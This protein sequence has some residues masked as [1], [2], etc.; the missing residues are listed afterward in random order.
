MVITQSEFRELRLRQSVQDLVDLLKG[1][2]EDG[3]IDIV[4]DPNEDVEFEPEADEPEADE[5]DEPEAE[6]EEPEA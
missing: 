3:F 5:D 2:E 6:D 1:L 4:A